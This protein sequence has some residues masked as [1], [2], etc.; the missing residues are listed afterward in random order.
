MSRDISFAVPRAA[1]I[2]SIIL[3]GILRE[4]AEGNAAALRSGTIFFKL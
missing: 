1:E 4:N 2:S 3:E